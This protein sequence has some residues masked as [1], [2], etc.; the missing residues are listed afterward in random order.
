MRQLIRNIFR[1]NSKRRERAQNYDCTG[2][3]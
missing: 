2:T 3:D 1:I